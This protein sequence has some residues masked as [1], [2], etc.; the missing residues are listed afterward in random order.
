M[1]LRE[2]REYALIEKGLQYN[3]ES[4]QWVARLPWIIDP[5]MLPNNELAALNLLKSVERKLLKDP[6]LSNLYQAQMEDMIAR[7]V[8][9]KLDPQEIREYNGPIY[10]I[11][12][13]A[14]LRPG[15]KS[16]P[17]R[18]VFNS[19][20]NFSGHVL[21]DYLAKGPN[22]LNNLLGVLLRFREEKIGIVGDISKMYH[23]INITAFDQM[24]HCFFLERLGHIERA[25]HVCHASCKFRR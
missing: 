23:A 8:C 9:R 22:M 13:Q 21:N 7:K 17:C 15:S 2:A 24:T 20:A 10:Y 11:A 1:S 6:K 4:K 14:V 25:G 19:S 12:H 16:T 5:R 3:S 18:I